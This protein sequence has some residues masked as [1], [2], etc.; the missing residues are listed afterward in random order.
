MQ[1]RCRTFFFLIVVT[2]VVLIGSGCNSLSSKSATQSGAGESKSLVIY[3]SWSGNT[4]SIAAKVH[5]KVGGDLV[6]IEL[7]K[8]YP[9]DYTACVEEYK[10]ERASGGDRPLKT[11]FENLDQYEVVYLGFPI[12]ASTLPT[13]MITLLRENDFSGKTIVPFAS[14]GGGGVGRSVAALKEL[15]PGAKVL[16]IL[17]VYGDGGNTLQESVDEWLKKNGVAR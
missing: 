5:D 7:V 6:E 13:P 10:K 8:P 3:Y 16:E 14:H 4:K 1:M 17:S 2:L 11:R 15:A 12:W 9:D